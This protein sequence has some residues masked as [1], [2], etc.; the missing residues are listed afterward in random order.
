MSLSG[1]IKKSS[2]CRQKFR[3][4]VENL[5][6]K[7]DQA[8]VIKKK[9]QYQYKVPSSQT[10][11]NDANKENVLF[12]EKKESVDL[13]CNETMEDVFK[14]PDRDGSIILNEKDEEI[15]RIASELKSV[16]HGMKQNE[17]YACIT[18]KRT[19]VLQTIIQM[20]KEFR[21]NGITQAVVVSSVALMDWIG[22]HKRDYFCE[23][24]QTRIACFC[25]I[26][27]MKSNAD[28]LHLEQIYTESFKLIYCENT[29]ENINNYWESSELFQS[30]ISA[31][32]YRDSSY[33]VLMAIYN[34]Y[35]DEE[36]NCLLT[37]ILFKKL[38]CETKYRLTDMYEEFVEIVIQNSQNT[39]LNFEI[40]QD[41]ITA[42]SR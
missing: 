13:Y 29:E 15:S 30:I 22:V 38:F 39:H 10:V 31:G 9:R 2:K 27:S 6:T 20:Y 25:I 4:S 26:E 34:D 35:I 37:D 42:I 18:Q 5:Y 14:M 40:M 33:M 41:Y 28:N 12:S 16:F 7:F 24:N 11:L 23:E 3:K 32:K 21:L 17:E 36:T 1:K 8:V 19:T